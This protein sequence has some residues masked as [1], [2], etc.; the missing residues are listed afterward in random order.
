[1]SNKIT[2]KTS[3][4]WLFITLCLCALGGYLVVAQ[5]A[6]ELGETALERGDYQEAIQHFADAEENGRTL[7]R[8]GY[9][10]SQL[11]RYAD[12]IRAY[13]D[14]LH[15][16]TDKEQDLEAQVTRSQARLGLGYIAYQQGRFDEAIRYYVEV[17]QQ[18]MAGIAEAHHNLGRNLCGTWRD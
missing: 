6:H 15:F 3:L 2:M 14:A 16:E 10:Y 8:L 5:N 9:A 11:G 12:A 1:M 4:H 18:G 17:V 13:Q 7:A